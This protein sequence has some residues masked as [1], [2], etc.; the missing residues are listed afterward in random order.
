MVEFKYADE[1]E[2]KV[3]QLMTPEY[4]NFFG[5]VHGGEVLKFVDN[6]AYV[7]CAR[8]SGKVCVTASFDRVD[9]IEPVHVGELLNLV[10]RIVYVGKTSMQ[11]EIDI[12]AEDLPTGN[13]RHTNSCHVTMVALVD[14]KPS[15]V[16]KLICR[17]RADKARFIQARSRRE[18]GFKYSEES[19]LFRSTYS[20]MDDDE[21]DKRMNEQ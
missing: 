21:L 17:N 3:S 2:V 10:A 20:E 16:P 6:M 1:T 4:A 11:V 7:C 5:N 19:A 8:Y 18:L 15:P 14:G 9:F 12:Y 13:I